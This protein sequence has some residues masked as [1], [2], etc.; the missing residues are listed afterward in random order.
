MIRRPPRSTLFPYTTLFRS[1]APV[2]VRPP[3]RHHEIVHRARREHR[4]REEAEREHASGRDTQPGHGAG[5]AARNDTRP[6]P[7]PSPRLA[8]PPLPQSSVAVDR[9][10]DEERQDERLVLRAVVE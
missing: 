10:K 9:G 8:R 2:V 7:T 1:G 3:A 5:P 6:N 4:A